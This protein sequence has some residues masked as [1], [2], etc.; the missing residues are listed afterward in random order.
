MGRDTWKGS[1]GKV[2][3]SCNLSSSSMPLALAVPTLARDI[4]LPVIENLRC[5]YSHFHLFNS[6]SHVYTDLAT[7]E[8]W[9]MKEEEMTRPRFD[10]INLLKY[11]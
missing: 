7:P 3:N 10:D 5:S 9:P 6:H 4:S 2:R 11:L 1:E 8:N